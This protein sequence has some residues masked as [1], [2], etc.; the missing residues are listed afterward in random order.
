MILQSLVEIVRDHHAGLV[1]KTISSLRVD[2]RSQEVEIGT[3]FLSG[4][5]SKFDLKAGKPE[6]ELVTKAE[7]ALE[8][9]VINCPSSEEDELSGAPV[10]LNPSILFLVEIVTVS[11][12]L[13]LRINILE[14]FSL[15]PPSIGKIM[16]V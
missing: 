11:V 15:G 6:L 9:V 10:V 3:N 5:A 12:E 4:F 16:F 1:V 7:V 2:L 8:S 13:L 14:K